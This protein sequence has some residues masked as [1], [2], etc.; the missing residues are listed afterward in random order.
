[1]TQARPDPPPPLKDQWALVTGASSGFG[2]DFAHILAERG[3][4][5]VLVARTP[6]PMKALATGLRKQH[7]VQCLVIPMDLTQPDA[8]VEL[9]NMLDANNVEI[10]LLINNAG[11][12]VFGEFIDQQLEQCLNMLELNIIALTELTHIFAS[13][14]ASRGHGRILLVGSL[15]SF[16]PLPTYAAYAAS[17]AYVLSFGEALHIELKNRGVS[18]TV[19]CPGATATN[20]LNVSGQ[21]AGDVPQ[22]LIMESRPV[23]EV[24]I[25][26]M[27]AGKASVVPGLTNRVTAFSNRLLPRG[28]LP[29]AAYRFLKK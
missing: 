20:F 16:Q 28:V 9:K 10:E 4:N 23:C 7:G 26:A 19:L 1:M 13:E 29:A 3:A 24:G 25:D 11:Y 14:M 15:G 22:S 18:V 12:G 21:D 5:L 27:L 6:A 8:A 2:V 17:K